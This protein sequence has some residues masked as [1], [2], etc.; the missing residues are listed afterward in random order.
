MV[1]AA[2]DMDS[3]TAAASR[4]TIATA[5]A[6]ADVLDRHS[7]TATA[8]DMATAIQI[9]TATTTATGQPTMTISATRPDRSIVPR[10][11]RDRD[12]GVAGAEG[13]ASPAAIR[14]KFIHH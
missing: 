9:R 12:V 10:V 5:I 2:A 8:A 3:V 14:S 13:A 1:T 11:L 7:P 6:V 4:G